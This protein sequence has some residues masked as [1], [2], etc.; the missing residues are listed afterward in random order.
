M[1]CVARMGIVQIN[2][3]LS[4]Q[5]LCVLHVLPQPLR[6]LEIKHR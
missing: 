6:R 5:L 2:R 4:L 3:K 1:Q